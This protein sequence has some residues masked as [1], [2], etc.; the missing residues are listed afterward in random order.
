MIAIH[1]R[2]GSFSEQWINYCEA[3]NLKYKIVDCYSNDIV[4]DLEDCDFLLWHWIQNDI[5]SLLIA[6]SLTFAL[7]SNGLKIFPN[8]DTCWHFDDKLAQKYHLESINASHV[9]SYVFYDRSSAMEWINKTMFPKVFKLRGGAGGENVKLIKTKNA[10]KWYVRK[11]FTTGLTSPRTHEVVERFWH[12][13]RD[14]SIA[15]FFNIMRGLLRIFKR[16]KMKAK[17]P[18]QRNYVYCQDF[19]PNNDHDIRVIVIGKRAFA[20]KRMVRENDFKASGSG[21]IIYEPEEIPDQCVKDAFHLTK[22]L[23]MQC[24]A[25][26]FIFLNGH[27]HVIEISYSFNSKA[28]LNCPGYWDSDLNWISE[29]FVPEHFMIEDLLS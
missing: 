15:S 19:I 29:T 6:K 28:Y 12:F 4:R 5:R 21:V 9:K 8:I 1:N 23:H 13:R 17:L 18:N 25:F 11:A 20:I 24:A 2:K 27:P 7:Q 26:D 10:A 22:E 14:R 3:N 16:N